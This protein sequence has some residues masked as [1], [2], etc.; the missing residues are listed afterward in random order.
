MFFSKNKDSESVSYT[1]VRAELRFSLNILL[2]T[3]N[4]TLTKKNIFSVE[5]HDS[6]G[7]KD[8]GTE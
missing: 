4:K 5:E 3:Y 2:C 6:G 8:S 7:T 1:L